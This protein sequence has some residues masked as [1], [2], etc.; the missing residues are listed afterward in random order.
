MRSF[1][2]LALFAAGVAGAPMP[3]WRRAA[4]VP[5]AAQIAALAPSLGVS[6][7]LPPTGAPSCALS[8]YPR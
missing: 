4:D 6:P 1:A 8:A 7:P 2:A 3:V 5:T